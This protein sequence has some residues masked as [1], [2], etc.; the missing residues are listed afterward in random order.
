MNI[1]Q[2]WRSLFVLDANIDIN[3]QMVIIQFKLLD[4]SCF[5][6]HC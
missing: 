1:L 2:K 4:Y 5:F 6:T 3:E